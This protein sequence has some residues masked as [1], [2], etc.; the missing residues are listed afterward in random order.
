M[1][2]KLMK[3]KR[4]LQFKAA[5]FALITVSMV[6]YGIGVWVGSWNTQYNSGLT[7]D[8]GD[9]E[10]L[11]EL[12]SY[13]SSSKGNVS[14]RSSFDTTG[15]GDFEGTS[16]RGAFGV[17]NNIFTPFNVLL[18]EGGLID[19]IEDRFGIPNYITIGFISL[20]TIAIIFS[21]IALFF[22]KPTP[23]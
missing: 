3:D 9:Y 15:S 6:L 20:M 2:K 14:V 4:G 11:D 17:I 22:R 16:L 7:Y 13:A 18:G 21:L 8:L 12:S 23:A 1:S 5:L 10:K 19:S